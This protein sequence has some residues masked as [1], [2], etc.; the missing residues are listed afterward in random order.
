MA[1]RVENITGVGIR[2]RFRHGVVLA[3]LS[4]AAAV[5]LI[6]T[7]SPRWTRLLLFFPIA[8]AANGFLQARAKTCVVLG[9]MGTRETN[10]G[11]YAR[12]SESECGVA[13]RQVV[14]IVIEDVLI[15]AVAT[16]LV[17]VV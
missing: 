10:E 14:S 2:R 7:G 16:A 4:V 17:W 12:M 15:A 3:F 13:R 1:A 11:G 9:V 5:I 6:A 8:I